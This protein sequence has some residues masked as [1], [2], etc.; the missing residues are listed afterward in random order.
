MVG[1]LSQASAF[2]H[3]LPSLW[4][5]LL[6]LMFPAYVATHLVSCQPFLSLFIY[7][8]RLSAVLHSCPPRRSLYLH[9]GSP[10]ASLWARSYFHDL[11]TSLFLV[12]CF[13]LV[14]QISSSFLRKGLWTCFVLQ[15]CISHG[16]ILSEGVIWSDLCLE[17]SLWLPWKG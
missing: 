10:F 1:H 15:A 16:R 11:I 9:L 12:Y 6:L 3:V 7:E 17:R 2:Y 5:V 4:F 8:G 13:I 14:K